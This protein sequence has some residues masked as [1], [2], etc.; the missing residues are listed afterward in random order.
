MPAKQGERKRVLATRSCVF[1]RPPDFNRAGS[2][3]KSEIGKPYKAAGQ[4]WIK[5]DR[6]LQNGRLVNRNVEGAQVKQAS[7]LNSLTVNSQSLQSK[8][9]GPIRKPTVTLQIIAD[10]G[11]FEEMEA[12]LDPGSYSLNEGT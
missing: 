10:D 11:G 4:Y 8:S 2:W 5:A 1:Y 12:L 3:A 7:S 9:T 6:Q